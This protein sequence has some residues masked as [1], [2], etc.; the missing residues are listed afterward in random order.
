MPMLII[1]RINGMSKK[2]ASTDEHERIDM[3]K[4]YDIVGIQVCIPGDQINKNFCKKLTIHLPLKDKE[5][6][7]EE[8]I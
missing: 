6:E 2:R 4:P 1:Y 7:A 3:N 5:D 8:I